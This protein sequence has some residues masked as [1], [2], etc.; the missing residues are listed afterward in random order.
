[1]NQP[2]IAGDQ[3]TRGRMLLHQISQ[4]LIGSV[5]ARPIY[6][7][8]RSVARD[9]HGGGTA[10]LLTVDNLKPILN[11]DLGIDRTDTTAGHAYQKTGSFGP[12]EAARLRVEAN[13][14]ST[15]LEISS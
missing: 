13:K 7:E 5:V 2:R 11:P 6:Q 3:P 8:D 14:G 12:S 4:P 1:M 9:R 10:N 15:Q